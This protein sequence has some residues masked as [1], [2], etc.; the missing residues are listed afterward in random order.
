[1]PDIDEVEETA[2]PATDANGVAL[3]RPE[4]LPI[5][6]R[7]RAEALVGLGL[8]TDEGGVVSDELIADT[9]ERLAAEAKADKAAAKS[10]KSDA[11]TV[12][13]ATAEGA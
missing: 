4:G 1:M 12:D 6:H 7:L 8:K 2:L 11:T 10:K 9:A 3:D 13:S 5:N